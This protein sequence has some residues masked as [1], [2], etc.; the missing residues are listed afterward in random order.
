MSATF[1]IFRK[2]QRK[3]A[4]L[5]VEM[6]LD[7]SLIRVVFNRVKKK[8]DHSFACSYDSNRKMRFF[9]MCERALKDAILFRELN[10]IRLGIFETFTPSRSRLESGAH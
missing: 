6:A 9:M 1:V 5:I 7:D 2:S 3:S 4:S 10:G 8:T